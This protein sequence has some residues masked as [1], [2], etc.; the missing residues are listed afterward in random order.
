VPDF[1]AD[2][3]A[4][5]A[6][7]LDLNPLG[8]QDPTRFVSAAD[9]NAAFDALRS[10]RNAVGQVFSVKAY[11]AVGDYVGDEQPAFQAAYD[12]CAA[13]GGGIVYAPKPSVGYRFQKPLRAYSTNSVRLVGDGK[14]AP[15]VA[16]PGLAGPTIFACPNYAGLPTTASRV[17]GGGLAADYRAV[18]DNSRAFD[19]RWGIGAD[20]NGWGT[21]G[22]HAA[23]SSG[24]CCEF[25]YTPAPA[26]ASI[27]TLITGRCTVF[28]SA[29]ALIP[30]EVLVNGTTGVVSATLTVGGAAKAVDTGA[31]AL[32]MD[33]TVTYH[34][35]L[36]YDGA[37]IRIFAA[38]L[39]ASSPVRGSVGA[40]GLVTS[41]GLCDLKVGYSE[42]FNGP[43]GILDEITLSY[44]PRYVGTFTAPTAKAAS[45]DADA[46]VNVQF[47][48]LT[49]SGRMLTCEK[50]SGAT[51]NFIPIE[52]GE[53]TAQV[54]LGL[55]DL[56]VG[57]VYA[58]NCVGIDV[59][60]CS[61]GGR[62]GLY[63]D[64]NSFEAHLFD[65]IAVNCDRFA[66]R[67]RNACGVS[68]IDGFQVNGALDYAIWLREYSG[69]LRD[70]YTGSDKIPLI[71][72]SGGNL[73]APLGL[74]EV[75]LTNEGHQDPTALA[76]LIQSNVEAHNCV[77]QNINGGTAPLVKVD[78][79]TP[80]SETPTI[81]DNCTFD[82]TAS[83]QCLVQ[84]LNASPAKGSVQIRNPVHSGF[85]ND[86][87]ANGVPAS[88]PTGLVTVDRR[89]GRACATGVSATDV[90][91]NNLRGSVTIAA[92]STSA[93]VVFPVAE[94]DANYFISLG[95]GA[96]SGSPPAAALRPHW[97]SKTA[98]GFTA[99]I[100]ADPGVGASVAVDWALT[101]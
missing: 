34:I 40:T 75:T 66:L 33:G 74:Y 91:A 37:T 42:I 90:A 56:A 76:A 11:G 63:L 23:G 85:L 77:F 48:G 73:G 53:Y 51:Y 98:S 39:G 80:G 26:D 52:C 24:L 31:F 30:L 29:G 99:T 64:N 45:L 6:A 25:I 1:V 83:T 84:F 35:A 81:F 44:K 46:R 7:K 58:V 38:P 94:A 5:P 27:R 101:R 18:A 55:D 41:D 68:R 12:A 2:N 95:A 47:G 13:A 70:V 96:A 87:A 65:C 43:R 49:D 93:S 17:P 22:G 97:S 79:G 61:F 9:L 16:A 4:L 57:S 88:S 67:T 10:L 78:H 59:R 19:L 15:G 72:Q 60:S 89:G 100:E 21:T 36:T 32:T 14:F 82:T 28:P 20:I 92:G 50:M 69:S 8:G 62:Y 86:Y 54:T 71:V 3:A